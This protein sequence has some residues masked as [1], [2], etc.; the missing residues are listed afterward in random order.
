MRYQERRRLYSQNFLRDPE[1]VK[2]LIRESS[3]GENDTV[4]EIGPGRGIITKELVKTADKVVAVEVDQNLY[5]L[6]KVKF[7]DAHNLELYQGNILDFKLPIFQYKVFANIPFSTTA[8]IVRKLIEDT[9]FQEGYLVVQKEAAR[10]FIGMPYDRKNQMISVLIKPWFDV[11]VFYEFKIDDFYPKPSVDILMIR[12]SK[13][14]RP[15]IPISQ[16]AVYRDFI[17]YTYNRQRIAK[18]NFDK[19]LRLFRS[20][21]NNTNNYEKRI[22]KNKA[23]IILAQQKNLDKIHRTRND[24]N[25]RRFRQRRAFKQLFN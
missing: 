15:I 16:K 20:F 14:N 3:I 12:I 8:D 2:K 9:L 7:K 25:W 10:K 23:K 22:V 21:V 24:K 18:L 6:L 1:L 13:L 11:S 5:F 17:L 4:L 19:I